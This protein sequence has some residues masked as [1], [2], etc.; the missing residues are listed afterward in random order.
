M[1]WLLN[2]AQ[3]CLFLNYNVG[4]LPSTP[5]LK[6]CY[7]GMATHQ[8][9]LKTTTDSGGYVGLQLLVRENPMPFSQKLIRVGAMSDR[10]W[11]WSLMSWQLCVISVL[12]TDVDGADRPCTYVTELQTL[13]EPTTAEMIDM[14]SLKTFLIYFVIWIYPY[15]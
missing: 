3:H 11:K 7:V 2:I 1:E 6:P 12:G 15:Q 9:Q 13:L 10:R 14:I 4:Q 5:F 8:R